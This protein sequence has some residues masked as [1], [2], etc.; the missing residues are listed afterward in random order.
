LF[1]KFTQFNIK[2]GKGTNKMEIKGSKVM[3]LGGYGEVGMAI[4]HRLLKRNPKELIIT[5]LRKEE[6]LET[7]AKLHSEARDVRFKPV[8]GNL[9]VRWPLKDILPDKLQSTPQYQ[10]WL[11]EDALEELNEEILTS[12]TLYRVI[13]KH[14]PEII[15][16][17]INTATA[18]AYQNIYQGYQEML[19]SLQTAPNVKKL[20][21]RSCSIIP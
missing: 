12:S 2:E 6:A 3:V 19:K 14:R 20:T 17:C 18:L 7:V 4:C 13:T 9:F 11:A 15:I 16:D 10:K 1:D 8:Y 5:S 21:H